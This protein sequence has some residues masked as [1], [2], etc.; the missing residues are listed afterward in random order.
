MKPRAPFISSPQNKRPIKG[1]AVFSRT[2]PSPST[3]PPKSTLLPHRGPYN[4]SSLSTLPL[5]NLVQKL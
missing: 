4:I 1:K 2:L 5:P 3:P